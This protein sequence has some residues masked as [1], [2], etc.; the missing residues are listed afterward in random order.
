[1]SG[2]IKVYVVPVCKVAVMVSVCEL[3]VA[4]TTTPFSLMSAPEARTIGSVNWR[5]IS[6]FMSTFDTPSSGTVEII[7]GGILSLTLFSSELHAL[8]KRVNKNV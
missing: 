7:V 3:N 2:I 1:L 8:R 6:L 4:R 5:V